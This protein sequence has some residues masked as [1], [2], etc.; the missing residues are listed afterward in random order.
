MKV[1]KNNYGKVA[2]A[3]ETIIEPKYPR[4]LICDE[5]ESEL[6]YEKSDI[7]MGVLGYMHLKCP[8][9][10]YD[11][12]LCDNE[13]NIVL[14]KDNVEFPTHFFHTSKDSA[15]DICNNEQVKK[16]IHNAISYFRENKEEFAYATGSGNLTVH[17]YRYS[18]D[19]EYY[20]VISNDYYDTYI[21]FEN[22][23]Y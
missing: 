9:C 23:D 19:E 14:T 10:G 5:C 17:V 13:N 11:N 8:L 3:H 7:E 16:Y 2:V 20:V 21:P 22:E 18:G 4:K 12:M 1:L 6:E 15:V